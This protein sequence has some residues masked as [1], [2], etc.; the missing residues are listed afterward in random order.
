[1][2]YPLLDLSLVCDVAM[3]TQVQWIGNIDEALVQL[4]TFCI[5]KDLNSCYVPEWWLRSIATRSEIPRSCGNSV[6][7]ETI[8]SYPSADSALQI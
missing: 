6:A 8:L 1:M 7:G 5:L 4:D 3:E 2:K